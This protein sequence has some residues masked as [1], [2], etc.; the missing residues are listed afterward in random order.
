MLPPKTGSHSEYLWIHRSD[1]DKRRA[2]I[3]WLKQ[4]LLDNPQILSM[5]G[6]ERKVNKSVTA[7]PPVEFKMAPNAQQNP[8]PTR[9]VGQ[10]SWLIAPTKSYAPTP[11]VA[12]KLCVIKQNF[13]TP[14]KRK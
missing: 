6:Y 12:G 1:G 11:V 8:I 9:N 2:D 4:Y 14:R 5:L 10:P 7:S 3:N 13:S